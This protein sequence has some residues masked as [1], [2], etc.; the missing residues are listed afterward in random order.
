MNVSLGGGR[1]AVVRVPATLAFLAITRAYLR[2]PGRP[3]CVQT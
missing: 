3:L 2:F 1:V